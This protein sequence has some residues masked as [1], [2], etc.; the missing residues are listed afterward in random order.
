MAMSSYKLK[1]LTQ[2]VTIRV[3]ISTTFKVRKW[4]ALR[5]IRLAVLILGC[6]LEVVE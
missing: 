5:L 3:E 6:R 1:K 2:E 4:I